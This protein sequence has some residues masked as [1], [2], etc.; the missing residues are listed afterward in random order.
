MRKNELDSDTVRVWLYCEVSRSSN[1]VSVSLPEFPLQVTVVAGPPVEIQV[2]VNR[3][4]ITFASRVISTPSMVRSP[5]HNN[6]NVL[7]IEEIH[8]ATRHPA[9]FKSPNTCVYTQGMMF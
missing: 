8:W 6:V 9:S 1:T 7:I 3:V 5:G 2:R 4:I